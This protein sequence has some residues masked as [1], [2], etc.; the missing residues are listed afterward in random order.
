MSKT[1][2]AIYVLWHPASKEAATFSKEVYRWF[3][4]SSDYLL[5]SG[6]GVPVFLRS[7]PFRDTIS[8]PRAIQV[9]EADLNIAV[10]LADTN[11][12][13]DPA[14]EAYL[15]EIAYKVERVHMI[16]VALDAS[17]YRLSETP[18]RLSFLRVDERDDPPAGEATRL[19]RRTPRLLRRL[20]E[21]IGGQVAALLMA[22]S[23]P[24]PPLTIFLSRAKDGVDVAEALRSSFQDHGYS[25]AFFD[26]SDEFEHAASA[27]SAATIAI[28]SDG[29]AAR[30]WCHPEVLL[31]RSPRR[32]PTNRCC[33]VIQPLLVVDNRK[34]MPTHGIPGL[35]NATFVRWLPERALATVDL[36]M[37]E[38]MLR[39]YHRLRACRVPQ[40]SGRHVISWTPD[41]T[42]LLFLQRAAS[43]ALSEVA[44]PGCHLPETEL[45]T[46]RS[47]F[48]ALQLR[49][50]D[51]VQT[52]P[53]PPPRPVA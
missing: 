33:W 48:P 7:Q 26:D 21:I 4:A 43:G 53:E 40:A 3:H 35:A 24:P 52:L 10:V 42:T 23:T 25:C 45:N 30:Q 11:M 50:F 1:P 37:R 6:M 28:I 5:C 32:D 12:M 19:A 46:L 8:T 2:L 41:L 38:V 14:W 29:Y 36:M 15:D 20:T 18:R 31:A 49:T 16:L 44:Y 34:E 27:G 51:D 22:A 47:V 13:A 17:A 9:E 39:S